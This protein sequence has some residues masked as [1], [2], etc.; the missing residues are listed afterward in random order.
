MLSFSLRLPNIETISSLENSRGVKIVSP[1]KAPFAN[2]RKLFYFFRATLRKTCLNNIFRIICKKLLIKMLSVL[3][4]NFLFI[5]CFYHLW[6]Y[7]FFV[8]KFAC[9]RCVFANIVI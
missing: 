8:L 7:N 3:L 5:Y 1:T 2:K 9:I 4:L 6:F